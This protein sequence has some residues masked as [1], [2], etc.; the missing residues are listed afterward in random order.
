VRRS[1]LDR[2]SALDPR[3]GGLTVRGE[4]TMA[5]TTRPARPR[6]TSKPRTCS[7]PSSALGQPPCGGATGVKTARYS[8]VQWHR[9]VGG[10]MAPAREITARPHTPSG[11][12]RRSGSAQC[13]L[14]SVGG[15]L[16]T[17]ARLSIGAR[18]ERSLRFST[19]RG[20]T[21]SPLVR[22][23]RGNE[24]SSGRPEPA[25]S[26]LRGHCGAGGAP[27]RRCT[28][29]GSERQSRCGH[30]PVV[31]SRTQASSCRSALGA[32]RHRKEPQG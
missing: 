18:H 15:R 21:P 23:N 25:S 11:Y 12:A 22:S 9:H 1:R 3:D 32:E 6:R 13:C 28:L 30:A 17:S 2:S 19:C 27:M 10:P 16:A 29:F 4:L 5:G 24:A 8:V 7:T 14:S 26:G 20:C 31:R